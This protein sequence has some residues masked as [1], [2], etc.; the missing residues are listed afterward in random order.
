MQAPVGCRP[1]CRWRTMSTRRSERR[2]PDARSP[3]TPGPAWCV[4]WRDPKSV[5]PSREG[6]GAGPASRDRDAGRQAGR[7]AR[8]R[9]R[10]GTPAAGDAIARRPRGVLVSP[11]QVCASLTLAGPNAPRY[12]SSMPSGWVE[13]SGGRPEPG[14]G[15]GDRG[16]SGAVPHPARRHLH[17]RQLVDHRVRERFGV[18]VK[19]SAGPAAGPAL[20]LRDP[21]RRCVA[22]PTYPQ[23]GTIVMSPT[24]WKEVGGRVDP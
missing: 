12:L 8:G 24:R 16:W 4:P 15:Q 6:I 1:R 3:G 5:T 13:P 22:L 20:C 23:L 10:R 7:A 2:S 19:A 14:L 17:I 21:R 11:D 9:P 18:R